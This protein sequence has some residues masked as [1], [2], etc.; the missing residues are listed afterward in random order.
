V[1]ATELEEIAFGKVNLSRR[2][3]AQ[4]ALGAKMPHAH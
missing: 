3:L 4:H 1:H 2:S